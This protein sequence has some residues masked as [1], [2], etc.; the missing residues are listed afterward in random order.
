MS[1]DLKI[2]VFVLP[3]LFDYEAQRDERGDHIAWPLFCRLRKPDRLWCSTCIAC[4]AMGYVLCAR[5][6]EGTS[7]A[8]GD[9]AEVIRDTLPAFTNELDQLLK[10]TAVIS[11]IGLPCLC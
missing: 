9:F 2:S 5:L 10:T 8:F 4:R 7:A 1:C 3:S 6:F 11:S